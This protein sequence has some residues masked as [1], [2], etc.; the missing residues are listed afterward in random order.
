MK[1]EFKSDNKKLQR[2]LKELSEKHAP[3]AQSFALN[4]TAAY[5]K[6]EAVKIASK[7]TGVPTTILKNRI[8]VPRGKK[9]TIRGLKTVIFGGLWPV[10]VAKLK[11]APR[12]LKSGAVKYKT[13]KGEPVNAN[14]FMGKNTNGSD[15]VFV[16]KGT[17]RL[18]IKNVTVEIGPQVERAIQGFSGGQLAKD[19]YSKMLFSQMDR[20]VRGGL[21]R[22]GVKV[23]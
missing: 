5:I 21:I 13:M 22:M 6:R 11:P 14:A 1:V 16:R 10:K 7:A 15:S 3:A 2:H 20:R 8:A 17:A 12:K 23:T 9:S 19:K 18:P 4:S